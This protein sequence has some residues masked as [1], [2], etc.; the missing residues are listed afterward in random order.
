MLRAGVPQ[1]FTERPFAPAEGAAVL[2]G[3]P[4]Q[5]RE[6]RVADVPTDTQGPGHRCPL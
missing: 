5:A 4:C 1:S 2:P 3:G 6:T